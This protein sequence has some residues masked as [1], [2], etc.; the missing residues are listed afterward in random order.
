MVAMWT[1]R[2]LSAGMMAGMALVLPISGSAQVHEIPEIV[3]RA[4]K[5]KPAAKPRQ[6]TR[7]IPQRTTVAPQPSAPPTVAEARMAGMLPG[8]D[9]NIPGASTAT[10]QEFATVPAATLGD[11]LF[12]RPGVTGTA[13]APGAAS[14]P[15]IRGLDSFRVRIQENGTGSQDVSDLGEDHGVP[16]DPLA[17]ERVQVIRGPETLRYGSQVG[18]IVSATNDRIPETP[19]EQGI[20]G[21]LRGALTSVDKGFDGAVLLNAGSGPFAL[22]ADAFSRRA[23]D[24][25]IPGGVQPNTRLRAEGQAVGGSVFFDQGYA[26][27]ALSRFTSLYHVPGTEAAANN[28]RIDLEQ[29]KLTSKGE[30]RPSDGPIAALRYW[31]AASDYKHNELGRNED[32]VDGVRATFKNREQEARIEAEHM[33]IATPFGLLSGSVGMQYV[34]RS[35]STDGE[36]GALL[37]QTEVNRDAAYIVEQLRFADVYRLQAAGRIERAQF[38]STATTFPPDLLPP[39]PVTEMPAKRTHTPISGSVALLRDLPFGIVASITAEY[40]Q[41]SPDVLELFA[42]GAHDASGTFEIGNADL[43]KE[44]MKAVEVGIRRPAG[45]WRFEANAYYR[46]FN[47]F[48]YRQFTGLRCGEDF[49]SC[50]DP[51][52]EFLQIFFA[53]KD[54][55][56]VGGEFLTQRDLT[57]FWG[58]VF[59]VE[60]RYDFVRA[61]F[62]DGT[63]VPRI[64]PHRLGG[65]IYWSDGAW[66]TRLSL[67]HAFAQTETGVNETPTPGYNLLKAEVSYTRKLRNSALREMTVGIVGDNLL[68]D[69]M[70]NHVSFRKDEVVLPGRNVRLFANVR[71]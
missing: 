1:S 17:A 34:H 27:L 29:I 11:L 9:P 19:P 5:P 39:G 71:F 67:L 62:D 68:D 48:I 41:R 7:R 21:Q 64:P 16:I 2:I 44:T 18:G 30:W 61:R 12:T 70:R 50:G 33:K 14:R 28:T 53:Q 3:V 66:N 51:N 56:F 32:G 69:V 31:A 10:P 4:P 25:A 35:V 63:N 20:H 57:R 59:G 38:D 45:E 52:G 8:I 23:S 55:T 42:R 47:N 54:A 22:H 40:K 24:Y 65:G 37:P 15:I 46:H 6:A 60:G 43:K 49:D 58:G 26:G 13:F 36:A